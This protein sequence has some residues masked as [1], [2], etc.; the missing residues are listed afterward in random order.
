MGKQ[1]KYGAEP[2]PIKRPSTGEID[3]ATSGGTALVWRLARV[4]LGGKW[5]WTSLKARDVTRLHTI[6]SSFEA[7]TPRV[8][9]LQENL[10]DIPP[11]DLCAEAQARLQEVE[12]DVQGLSELRLGHAKW[13]VWGFVSGS[14]FDVL[15]WDPNHNVC[16]RYPAGKKRGRPN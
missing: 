1:P 7:S 4:D 9:R 13:R 3:P 5:G 16:K 10:R 2:R 12:D 6:M 11:E 14:I 8:L 15:W